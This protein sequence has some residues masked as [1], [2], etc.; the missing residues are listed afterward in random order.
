MID[1]CNVVYMDEKYD[2]WCC[3]ENFKEKFY[4]V[5]MLVYALTYGEVN[6]EVSWILIIIHTQLE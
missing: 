4:D 1:M 5:V 2:L 3:W 6:K